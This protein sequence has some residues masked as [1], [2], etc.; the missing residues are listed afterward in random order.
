MNKSILISILFFTTFQTYSQEIKDS[1]SVDTNYLEDQ[2]YLGVTYNVLRKQPADFSQNGLSGG[3]SLGFIKD[4][5]LNDDRNF[6]LG[7][8]LGYA[9]N[10]Y[11]QNL[12]ISSISNMNLFEVAD[13]SNFN[14]NRFLTHSLE[15]PL[16]LRWRTSKATKYNFWR[17]YA[18][19]K[20]GYVFANSSKFSDETSVS[21]L[22]SINEIQKF[23]YGLTFNTGYNTFNLSLY[24]GLNP[25]FKDAKIGSEQID[26]KQFN[27]GLMFYIL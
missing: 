8:G 5:P 1:L 15:M 7:I 18:G 2:I 16:E 19:A 23:Q 12:K 27:I 4:I 21:K 10:A 17:I 26:L 25:L 24:Y 20:I 6:G 3:L 22:K 9:Y 11:I 13:A 14:T